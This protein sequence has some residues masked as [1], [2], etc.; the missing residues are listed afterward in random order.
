VPILHTLQLS[1]QGANNFKE[2][3]IRSYLVGGTIQHAGGD[4]TTKQSRW[5]EEEEDDY[6]M[7]DEAEESAKITKL[8]TYANRWR[9]TACIPA[10][11]V[12]RCVYVCACVCIFLTQRP[13]KTQ[14]FAVPPAFA[15][16]TEGRCRRACVRE[17]ALPKLSAAGI[18]HAEGHPPAPGGCGNDAD[19]SRGRHDVSRGGN[20]QDDHLP[21]GE[22]ARRSAAQH[23]PVQRAGHGRGLCVCAVPGKAVRAD[24]SCGR[25]CAG[26]S[27]HPHHIHDGDHGTQPAGER[28]E[29]PAVIQTKY[30]RAPSSCCIMHTT[31]V[32]L[33]NALQQQQN[34][35][36]L[37]D[38]GTKDDGTRDGH[39]WAVAGMLLTVLASLFAT[40]FNMGGVDTMD[41]TSWPVRV[42]G[43]VFALPAFVT[44]EDKAAFFGSCVYVI[45]YCIRIIQAGG[46]AAA[47]RQK[48]GSVIG[49][50][51]VNPV[52]VSVTVA[53]QRI[54]CTLDNP[55]TSTTTFL[56]LTWTLHKIS[57]FERSRN[58]A[59]A[60]AAGEGGHDGEASDNDSSWP[61]ALDILL[62]CAL[63]ST[64][65]YVGVAI[66]VGVFRPCISRSHRRLTRICAA[67]ERHINPSGTGTSGAAC[68][69]HAQQGP[70]RSALPR[71]WKWQLDV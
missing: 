35:Q 6:V 27:Q 3:S 50:R 67:G 66:Q 41:E 47:R 30:G 34:S 43:S 9:A 10:R 14:G 26:D 33:G 37:E 54:Y 64:L 51:P 60:A 52:L 20:G 29:G 58:E 44:F 23:I 21:D 56:M 40:A 38:E 53:V 18:P 32:V 48:I 39:G 45:Y 4:A 24:R 63:L 2:V 55:Y 62:D 68:C 17:Q 46:R 36:Q 59:A 13:Q 19:G 28:E 31:Q 1:Q 25:P 42:L 49:R 57:V 5:W 15:H 7:M 65:L 11:Q 12:D 16:P 22:C 69:F 61:R 70:A 71:C 8:S